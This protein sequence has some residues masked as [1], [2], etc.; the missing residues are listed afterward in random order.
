LM[1][2][3]LWVISLFALIGVT[4]ILYA[5]SSP[6]YTERPACVRCSI[7]RAKRIAISTAIS[8]APL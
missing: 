8:T 2:A 3:G 7:S 5:V 6:S 4:L 1:A